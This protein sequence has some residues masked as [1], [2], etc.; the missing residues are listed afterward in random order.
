ME[1]SKRW[2]MIYLRNGDG[3]RRLIAACKRLRL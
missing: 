1:T 2:R 3:R